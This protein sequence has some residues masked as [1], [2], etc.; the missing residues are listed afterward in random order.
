MVATVLQEG[1]IGTLVLKN[2][3]VRA[4]TSETMASA[5]GLVSDRLVAFYEDLARGGAGLIVT[6]HIYVDRR[7]QYT[8]FQTGIHDDACIAGLRRLVDAV[9]RQGGTIFAELAHAGSQGTVPGVTPVAPSVVANAIFGTEP[10]ELTGDAIEQLVMGFRQGARRALAAGFDG[11]HLHGGNG[12]LISQFRSPLTNLRNDAWG[13]SAENRNRFFIRVYEAVRGEVGHDFPVTARIGMADVDPAGL[14]VEESVALVR[15]LE[16]RGLDAVEVTYNVMNTYRDNIRPYVGVR[17]GRALRDLAFGAVGRPYVEEAYY[18]PFARAVKAG[19]APLPVILVGGVRSTE[20][21]NDLIGSGDTD[22]V[23]MARPFIREP[24][25][26]RQIVEGRVGPV[27][28][29]S[30]NLCLMHEGSQSLR[31][32]RKTWPDLLRHVRL[33]YGRDR[34]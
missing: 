9:H 13:G 25:I 6:G 16:R 31:C 21:M 4:A 2:R 22:F 26:A 32:W 28:C 23:A 34:G 1:R 20:M 18:R 17:F 12:Y 7:G 8:P 24:D 3:I 29:V 14:P 5:E 15:E 19:G 33:H 30:C 10:D 27:D 11:I